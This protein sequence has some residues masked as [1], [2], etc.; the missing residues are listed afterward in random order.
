MLPSV[1]PKARIMQYGY[2]SRWFGEEAIRQKTTTVAERL[3]ISLKRARKVICYV[4]LLYFIQ[5]TDFVS[6]A[7]LS[8]H[9]LFYLLRTALVDWP[10]YRF[11]C[12][13][14]TKGLP[15]KTLQALLNAERFPEDWPGIYSA[16]YGI[17]FL[18]TPFRGAPGLTLSELLQA[19]DA[20]YQDTI[21]G[22]IL[23]ILEPDDE[24]LLKIV[25]IFEKIQAKSLQRAKITCFFEQK[26]CNVKAI[27]G[28]EEK[29]V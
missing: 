19:V 3:L 6:R 10:S 14:W 21:Q 16:T 13:L 7:L 2:M 20:E 17:V 27:L 4:M 26:P 18:G 24:S 12:L 1:V 29:K 5:S 8:N 25:Y 23:R 15:A 11:R 22:E 28:K 9:V